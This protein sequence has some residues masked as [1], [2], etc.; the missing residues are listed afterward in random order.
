MWKFRFRGERD[1]NDLGTTV[2]DTEQ[3]FTHWSRLWNIYHNKQLLT[4]LRE[5]ALHHGLK[6]RRCIAYDTPGAATTLC[7]SLRMTVDASSES[8]CV[9]IGFHQRMETFKPDN[10]LDVVWKMYRVRS[11]LMSVSAAQ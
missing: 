4:T 3:A 7:R 8:R 1:S 6:V 9:Q 5:L 2:K 10:Q 11:L